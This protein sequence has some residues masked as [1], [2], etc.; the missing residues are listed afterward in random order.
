[1]YEILVIIFHLSGLESD[2]DHLPSPVFKEVLQLMDFP[3]SLF[4]QS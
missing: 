3:Y 2:N 1:M 4:P